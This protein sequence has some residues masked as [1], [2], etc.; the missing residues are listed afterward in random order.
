[1][2]ASALGPPKNVTAIQERRHSELTAD[3]TAQSKRGM[4][5]MIENLGISSVRMHQS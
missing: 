3:I 1:M 5:G 2:Q 4:I